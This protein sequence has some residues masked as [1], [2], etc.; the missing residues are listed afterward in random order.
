[1]NARQRRSPGASPCDAWLDFRRCRDGGAEWIETPLRG[2]ALCDSPLL[3]KGTAFTEEEREAL[4]LRGLLPPYRCLME[5]QARRVME[6]YRKKSSDLERYIHLIALLDRNETLFYRVLL[7]N[8]TEMLPVVYTPTVGQACLQFGHIYRR[9][10]GLYL[11]PEDSPRMEAVLA[12]WPR[13]DVA[14]IVVTDGERILGLGDLGAGGMGI[15]VGK[16][17]LYTAAAGIRPERTLPVCFDTGTDNE[18]L[19][20]DPLYLGT[21]RRRVRGPQYDALIEAFMVEARRRWPGVLV[22]FED[23]AKANAARLL[24]SW[25][26]R[27]LC[28]NDD[29]QGTGAVTLAG[30]LAALRISGGDFDA[31]RVVVA[32]AGSAGLGIA[33]ML[34]RASV[35]ILDSKGLLTTDR[36]DL[37]EAQRAFARPEP[38]G[39]LP[40]IARRVRPTIL[41]GTS[42]RP[43]LFTKDIVQ[44]M[45]GP[46]PIVFPLSNPTAKAECT[47]EQAREWSGGRAIVATGSPFPGTPQCNNLYIFP[48]VGLGVLAARAG[49]VTDGDFLAAARELAAIAGKGALFP[50]LADIRGISTRIALAVAENAIASGSA[51]PASREELRGRIDEEMWEPR[52]VEYRATGRT[53]RG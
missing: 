35:W 40:E 36:R 53:T 10:R 4:G 34:K 20:A 21:R 15:S 32:G 1:M 12:N 5:E 24:E 27:T 41:I 47:P 6:N 31:Q 30:V 7:D 48:G 26:E 49:R 22:Q 28:F 51:P 3:N 11:T 17:N 39:G 25:R 8:L 42:T 29:I 38:G 2:R 44:A 43:G 33:R 23:F 16:L 9:A 45:D 18:A 14:V 19:L 50:P 52:Y 46:R 13:P 37:S